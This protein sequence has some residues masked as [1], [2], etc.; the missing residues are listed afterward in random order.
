MASVLLQDPYHPY[1]VRFIELLHDKYGHGAVC[2]FTDRR[3]RVCNAAAFPALRSPL[4]EAVYDVSLDDLAGFAERVK[5]R[6]AI[7]GVV[8][9]AEPTVLAAAE[10]SERLGLGWNDRATVERFRD[11]YAFKEHLRAHHPHV[12][13][14]GSRL[15]KTVDD[16]LPGGV[17]VFPRYVLKPNDGWGNRDIA[18]LDASSPRA[19]VEALLAGAA[20]PLVMEEYVDGPEYFVN[21]Q[22]D[23]RGDAVVVAVFRYGRTEANGC[24]V[25]SETRSVRRSDPAFAVVEAYARDVVRA[26]GLTRSP[27]HL[28]VKVDARGP[29]LIEAGARLAGNENAWV[30]NRLHGD[31]LDLFDV[32]AHYY[33]R[34]TDYGPMETNWARYDASSAVY[35]HGLASRRGRLR[36]VR[37]IREVEALPTFARWVKKPAV[38]DRI[39]PTVSSLTSPGAPC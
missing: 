21:G 30:C 10:L 34:T 15:V 26:S 2:F 23:A 29:C 18:Y 32:A 3:T 39:E 9:F 4:V 11:K 20:R 38:G 16:V 19:A 14:N 13:V 37:G 1:A 27:F 35:V 5:Q 8:P 7:A 28:E 24:S 36:T 31:A 6:H 12:R 17:P 33:V 25:D 22:V